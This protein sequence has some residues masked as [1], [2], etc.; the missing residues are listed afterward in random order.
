M[1]LVPPYQLINVEITPAEKFSCEFREILKSTY[2]V[3]HFE[4]LLLDQ[5]KVITE[6]YYPLSETLVFFGIRITESA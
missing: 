4:W 3:K 5:H 2:F 1:L 6:N